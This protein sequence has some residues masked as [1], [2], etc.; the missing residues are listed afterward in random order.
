M[1]FNKKYQSE[2]EE[3]FRMK[4]F[5]ENRRRIAKHNQMFRTGAVTF[6]LAENHL[7]DLLPNEFKHI[8][9]GFNKT[10]PK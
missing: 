1:K 9:N 6:E 10:V 7:A 4:I 5:L 2:T 8:Y 3:K